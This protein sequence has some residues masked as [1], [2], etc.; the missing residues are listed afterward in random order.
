M[1]ERGISGALPPKSTHQVL[2]FPAPRRDAT[3]RE[4]TR[5]VRRIAA[6]NCPDC[7]DAAHVCSSVG[8]RSGGGR[9]ADHLV[10]FGAHN[11]CRLLSHVRRHCTLLGDQRFGSTRE[12]LLRHQP[13]AG[14]RQEHRRHGRPHGRI[15][16]RHRQLFR[17]CP[18]RRNG[19]AAC[20]GDNTYGQLGTGN[21]LPASTPVLVKNAAGSGAL[22][23]IVQIAAGKYHTCAR[24][25][26]GSISCWGHNG[27]YELGTG[28]NAPH[29]LPVL[30]RNGNNSGV[31]TGTVNIAISQYHSCA[32]HSDGSARCWGLNQFGILG[33][34]TQKPRA[35][36]VRI[37]A[38]TG[39]GFLVNVSQVSAA[40]QHTCALLK[41]KTLDCW[42]FN[43]VAELGDGTTVTRLRPVVVKNA[44]GKAPLANVLQVSAGGGSNGDHTCV[45]LANSTALCWG[46]NGWATSATAPRPAGRFATV[47]ATT[48]AGPLL[49]VLGVAAGPLSTCA[50]VKGGGAKCWGFNQGGQFGNGTAVELHN[51]AHRLPSV[52]ATSSVDAYVDD[53]ID[54][55]IDQVTRRV[56]PGAS[57]VCGSCALRFPRSV[58]RAITRVS[59]GAWMGGW[60]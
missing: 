24:I 48:G 31:L 30:V 25:S 18:P 21:T 22:T 47:K 4:P 33:D 39:T 9:R 36:P 20:W 45:R 59:V 14:S 8:R 5:G 13:G 46:S 11:V 58:D 10:G 16:D 60:V 15:P 43:G 28:N 7:F 52:V 26:N 34:G 1:V 6:L 53:Q 40:P 57:R 17:L 19:T 44:A 12:R 29:L 49:N 54:H 3:V 55:Q 27:Y 41:N 37:R 35:L 50:V 56:R 42:G 51:V 32:V 23:G 2:G 38:V